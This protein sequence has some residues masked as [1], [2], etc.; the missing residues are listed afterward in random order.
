MKLIPKVAAIA[1]V[2]LCSSLL[3]DAQKIKVQEGDVAV[4]KEQTE[5]NTEFTYDHV[6]VG[7]FDNE[8]DYIQKKKD[9][10]NKKEAGKGD[11]W[12]TAWKADRAARFEPRFNEM[13]TEGS[14]GI[15]AGNF[16]A[17][18]YTLIFNTTFVEPGF[19]VG[20]M[21][22]NAYINGEILIVETADKSKVVARI[23]VDKAPGRMAFGMDFDTGA[24]ITESYAMA[25]RSFGRYVRK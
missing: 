19:N 13:F 6:K 25:G 2:M 3:A 4:L 22:K 11:T 23:S 24:R 21:R 18:K 20:V 16:P 14:N 7:E 5:I 12:A 1:A 9:E 10:Y 17:A 8:D 15:K